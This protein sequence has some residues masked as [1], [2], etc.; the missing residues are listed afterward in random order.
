MNNLFDAYFNV[1]F[2][3]IY[4][5]SSSF[6]EYWQSIL[7]VRK[8]VRWKKVGGVYVQQLTILICCTAM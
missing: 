2:V 3:I 6:L 4:V 1:T 8:V 7:K 5:Y